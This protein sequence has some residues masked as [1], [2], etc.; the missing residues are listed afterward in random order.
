MHADRLDSGPSMESSPAL[1]GR[2]CALL[3]YESEYRRLVRHGIL[4]IKPPD[5]LSQTP[6]RPFFGSFDTKAGHL[7]VILSRVSLQNP[8]WSLKLTS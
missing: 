7:L 1:E 8:P 3:S 6:L 4:G 5:T 2:R